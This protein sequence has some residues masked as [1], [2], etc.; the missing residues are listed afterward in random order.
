MQNYFSGILGEFS[1]NPRKTQNQQ[2]NIRKSDKFR[3]ISDEN[4][5][6]GKFSLSSHFC[7][8]KQ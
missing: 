4:N 8:A 7:F 2:E 5:F 3:Q 1:E 6:F